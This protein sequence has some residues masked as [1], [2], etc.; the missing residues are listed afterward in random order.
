[1]K[2]LLIEDT[3]TSATIVSAQL[4]KL[5]LESVHARDGEAGLEIFKQSRPDLILLDVI[6]PGLDG[7]EVARR[8]RLLEKDG[9]WTPIIFLTARTSDKDLERGIEAGGDDYLVKPVSEIVLAAKVRAMQR[10]AQMRLS[11]LVLTRRLDDANRELKR[12]TSVDGLTGIANRRC[13][14][15]SIA[16][17]WQRSRRNRLPLSMLMLDVDFFKQ[18]NDRYGHQT[19]DECLK[20]VANCLQSELKRPADLVA[21]FGGEE[22]VVILPETN[23]VGAKRVAEAMRNAL[24]SLKLPH[25]KSAVSDY[26]TASVGVTTVYPSPDDAGTIADMLEAADKALYLAK[27]AGRNQVA[28]ANQPEGAATV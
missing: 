23:V 19:G 10:L 8:I 4:A 24:E 16:R 27:R 1:M 3:V 25:D 22:F 26:V 7:F 12:L 2:V 9:D 5:G 13:F 21:R 6:M 17:E 18:Y 20:A 11:L 14:D 15:E 28:V